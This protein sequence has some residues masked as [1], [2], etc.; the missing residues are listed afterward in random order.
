MLLFVHVAP[1]WLRLFKYGGRRL[2]VWFFRRSVGLILAVST[3]T[4][5]LGREKLVRLRLLVRS[6][7]RVLNM[8]RVVW[9]MLVDHRA[10]RW[11]V[12]LFVRLRRRITLVILM[13]TASTASVC[14]LHGRANL[15]CACRRPRV[16][17]L[18]GLLFRRRVVY[19]GGCGAWRRRL[20]VLEHSRVRLLVRTNANLVWSR[21]L[22][23]LRFRRPW[24]CRWPLRCLESETTR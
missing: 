1:R 10:S 7:H 19:H 18:Y 17:L 9:R 5:M 8:C 24:R 4:D 20:W 11:S 22:L 2:R 15:V 13:R 14:R 23:V 16:V 6:W 12:R 21:L 3:C